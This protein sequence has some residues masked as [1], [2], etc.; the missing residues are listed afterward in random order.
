[1]GL[2]GSVLQ[3]L[4]VPFPAILV[5]SAPSRAPNAP[6]LPVSSPAAGLFPARFLALSP[7]RRLVSGGYAI[8]GGAA[9][10]GRLLEECCVLGVLGAFAPSPRAFGPTPWPLH[11]ARACGPPLRASA[12]GVRLARARGSRAHASS[13][14]FSGPDLDPNPC[15]RPRFLAPAGRRL[16]AP[17]SNGSGMSL[18]CLFQVLR[19]WSRAPAPQVSTCMHVCA[20]T[21]TR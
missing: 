3:A 16:C 13:G 17:A 12:R 8:S 10:V 14:S 20:R 11:V 2:G 5:L 15:S 6:R 4:T 7:F 21:V 1:M 19:G 18:P 9:G